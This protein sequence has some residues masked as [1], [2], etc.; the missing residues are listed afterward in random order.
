MKLLAFIRPELRF[1]SVDALI[2]AMQGDI[3]EARAI[4]A[5]GK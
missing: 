4:N 5:S 3:E 2:A 1:E